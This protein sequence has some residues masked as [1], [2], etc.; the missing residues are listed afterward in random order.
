MDFSTPPTALDEATPYWHNAQFLLLP[1]F[2]HTGDV[3][4]LKPEAFERLVTSYYVAGDAGDSLFVYQPL[5]F[6]PGMSLVTLAKVLVA[7]V[8]VVPLLLAGGAV[9]IMRRVRRLASRS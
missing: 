2:S 4:N 9:W 5:R 8:V 7:A 6:G 3:S 1:E